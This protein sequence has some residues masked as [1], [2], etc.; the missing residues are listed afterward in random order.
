[1]LR[2]ERFLFPTK[3]AQPSSKPSYFLLQFQIS[4][5]QIV[6][7]TFTANEFVSHHI[8]QF[9]MTNELVIITALACII[10]GLDRSVSV[11]WINRCTIKLLLSLKRTQE[12]STEDDSKQAMFQQFRHSRFLIHERKKNQ[13]CSINS[14]RD[15]RQI[16][17]S[18]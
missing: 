14:Y 17:S 13:R 3:P 2:K 16:C 9:S 5:D 7:F 8:Y 15:Q 18:Q 12:N 10:R 11:T 6:T 4:L 1:M